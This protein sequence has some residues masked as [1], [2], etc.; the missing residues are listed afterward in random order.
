MVVVGI[1][2]ILAA[3]AIP[4]L[5]RVTASHKIIEE[6]ARVEGFLLKARDLARMRNRCVQVEAAATTLTRTVFDTCTGV[7]AAFRVG[8]TPATADPIEVETLELK[9]LSAG[10]TP[11]LVFLPVGAV[12]AN[13]I[14][15][16]RFVSTSSTAVTLEI[17][18]ASGTVRQP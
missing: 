1:A 2:S 18:P 5:S 7:D 4:N 16:W 9:S 14:V 10:V 17:W 11:T 13:S 15:E 6:T 12:A 8:T 3:I